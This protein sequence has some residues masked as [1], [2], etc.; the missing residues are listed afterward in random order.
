MRVR[1]K[2][3]AVGLLFCVALAL[4][5][6][7]GVRTVQAIVGFE[8]SHQAAQSGD[9]R[10]IRP[11]M[12]VP[13]IARVYHVPEPYLLETLGISDAQSVRHVTLSRLATRLNTT[14]DSLVQ[15]LQQ[16]IL[17]YREQH[18]DQT[19]PPTPSA[20]PYSAMPPPGG[21]AT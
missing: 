7:F 17:T 15:E 21:R 6:I 19:P 9:V 5:I 16:A 2:E 10:T 1:A 3:L 4:T 20:T 12:T 8:H 11:W 18:P 13:Y 14:S